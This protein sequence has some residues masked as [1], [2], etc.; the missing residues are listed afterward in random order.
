MTP[1]RPLLTL[2]VAI[3]SEAAGVNSPSSLEGGGMQGIW[4][5]KSFSNSVPSSSFVSFWCL[6]FICYSHLPLLLNI[7]FSQRTLDLVFVESLLMTHMI[8][9]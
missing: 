6:G 9:V 7:R 8:S 2:R 1:L 5:E 3:C 4:S